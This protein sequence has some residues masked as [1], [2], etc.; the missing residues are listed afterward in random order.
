VEVLEL[1]P[2]GADEHV[3]H[4]E[5]MVGT[6][7]DNTNVDPVALVPAGEA[8]NNVNAVPGV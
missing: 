1:L 4:E 6:G 3:A 8:I 7:A 5:G 2:R